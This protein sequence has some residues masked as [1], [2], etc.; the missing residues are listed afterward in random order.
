M[1]G[2]AVAAFSGVTC[3]IIPGMKWFWWNASRA[4]VI[5]V[6][7]VIVAIGLLVVALVRVPV[8][9]NASAGFGPD[10]ECTAQTRGGPTCIKKPAK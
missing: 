7:V 6:L 3:D 1:A 4:D 5:G 2:V 8:W 9:Q 10:W